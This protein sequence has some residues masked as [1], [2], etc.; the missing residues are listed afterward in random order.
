[1][2]FELERDILKNDNF[3]FGE[4]SLT[5]KMRQLSKNRDKMQCRNR[6]SRRVWGCA[7]YV[8][9]A[10]TKDG[11]FPRSQVIVDRSPAEHRC[12]G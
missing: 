8:G 7:G 5:Q 11:Y 12:L 2:D 10:L 9:G 1:M 4:I 3:Y 6:I